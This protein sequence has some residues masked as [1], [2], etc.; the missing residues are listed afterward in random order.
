VLNL[1]NHE[2]RKGSAYEFKVQKKS[3]KTKICEGITFFSEHQ[4]ENSEQ[5]KKNLNKQ[6]SI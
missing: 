4:V 1:Y 2:S 3:Q 5:D 6:K